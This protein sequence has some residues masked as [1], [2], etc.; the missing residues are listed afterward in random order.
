MIDPFVALGKA[1]KGNGPS[2]TTIYVGQTLAQRRDCRPDVG[3]TLAQP[4]LLSG[5]LTWYAD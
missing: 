1:N 3:P 5:W 2:Q 4:T